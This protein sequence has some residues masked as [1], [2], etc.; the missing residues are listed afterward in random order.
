MTYSDM[1]PSGRLPTL[2]VSNRAVVVQTTLEGFSPPLALFSF[3]CIWTLAITIVNTS[4]SSPTPKSSLLR[5]VTKCR[6]S[7]AWWHWRMF[8][9]AKSSQCLLNGRLYSC[10]ATFQTFGSSATVMLRL[11]N[12]THC[13]SSSL[14]SH[15]DASLSKPKAFSLRSRA[16]GMYMNLT[17]SRNIPV[18]STRRWT[19]LPVLIAWNRS[20]WN[21]VRNGIDHADRMARWASIRTSSSSLVF[22]VFATNTTSAN[23]ADPPPIH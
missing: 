13:V 2:T 7:S 11:M 20:D 14:T 22:S 8:F 17:N 6:V 9:A 23:G 5:T 3:N 16:S 4:V 15:T 12:R 10:S 19:S 18:S 21:I 1:N